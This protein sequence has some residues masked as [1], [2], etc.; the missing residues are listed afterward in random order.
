MKRK[1]INKINGACIISAYCSR[2]IE[3]WLLKSGF[4]LN[5]SSLRSI[6]SA[7]VPPSILSTIK[8]E[9]LPPKRQNSYAF[10][11]SFANQITLLGIPT[12]YPT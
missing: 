3:Q 5:N 7:I 2:P 1:G 11:T 6:K 12:T 4:Q 8:K 9:G 10:Q